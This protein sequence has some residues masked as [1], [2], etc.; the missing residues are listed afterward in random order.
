MSIYQSLTVTYSSLAENDVY[1]VS[2]QGNTTS[3]TSGYIISPEHPADYP[4]DGSS[5]S[6]TVAARAGLGVYLRTVHMNVR[7]EVKGACADYVEVKCSV[8]D[9]NV[10]HCGNDPWRV[11]PERCHADVIV[12]LVTSTHNNFYRGFVIKFNC[13]YLFNQH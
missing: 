13:E 7:P 9:W 12:T 10:A 2:E 3:T 11:S 5:Y 6:V 4:H 1:R 8:G